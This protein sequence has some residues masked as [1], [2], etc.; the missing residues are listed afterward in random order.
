MS[1]GRSQNN[2]S[3]FRSDTGFSAWA[4]KVDDALRWILFAFC[5]SL[6]ITISLAE[7]LAFLLVMLWLVRWGR[8]REAW[9]RL[10]RAIAF[11]A[12]AF[13]VLALLASAIGP[14]PAVSLWKCHRLIYLLIPFVVTDLSLRAGLHVVLRSLSS[15]L[16]GV[17]LLGLYDLARVTWV[18]FRHD[19]IFASG[20]MRDP[21]FY[22]T[23]ICLILGVAGTPFR[24][25]HTGVRMAVYLAGLVGHF[26]RGAWAGAIGGIIA[27]G[28]ARRRLL[29]CL[30]GTLGAIVILLAIPD[31]R[32]RLK[33]IPDHLSER[34]G[35]RGVLWSRVAPR[36]IADH[37]WG[38]GLGAVRHKDLRDYSERIQPN[39]NHLHNNL[40]EIT[41]E[42]GWAGG[43]VWLAWM[44]AVL[45]VSWRGARS[46]MTSFVRSILA[47]VFGA[48]CALLI[49]GLAEYNFGDGEI[50]LLF[51][52]MLGWVGSLIRYQAASEEEIERV[53]RRA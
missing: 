10:P 17:L 43:M 44:L 21:Q 32:V 9:R 7:P 8:N 40:L 4:M 52:M 50:F 53:L 42:T 22:M 31:V 34:T 15:Y 12:A 39:L 27:M 1:V 30:V 3:M 14:R 25:R 47:G 48:C 6:P 46:A 18:V 19:E 37:P 29:R 41:L 36:I 13:A 45:T 28:L 23:A 49:N 51:C 16:M 5:I 2:A 33:E 11:P 35:G 20:N 26:K 24:S 38:M